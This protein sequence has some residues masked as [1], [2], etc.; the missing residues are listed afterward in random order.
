M[1]K[2]TLRDTHRS[3]IVTKAPFRVV[4]K[5]TPRKIRDAVVQIDHRRVPKRRVTRGQATVVRNRRRLE[6]RVLIEIVNQ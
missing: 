6:R 5:S 4:G 3:T 2:R 1:L